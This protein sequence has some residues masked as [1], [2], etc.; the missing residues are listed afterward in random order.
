MDKKAILLKQV[1]AKET[2]LAEEHNKLAKVKKELIENKL[3]REKFNSNNNKLDEILE[4]RRRDPSKEG[5]G[6][7]EM[8]KC[9]KLVL[10]NHIK[11]NITPYKVIFHYC[12]A[13]ELIRLRCF[14]M[15]HDLRWRCTVPKEVPTPH[16]T[17]MGYND[18]D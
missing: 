17:S 7:G 18:T 16:S 13:L 6:Y 9:L 15:L 14:K 11:K 4:A 12:G 5:L 10:I 8:G 1:E 2:L 3:M